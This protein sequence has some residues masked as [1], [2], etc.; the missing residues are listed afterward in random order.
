[1]EHAVIRG[2][3]F[4]LAGAALV[5]L[6]LPAL[7]L[8]LALSAHRNP[9]D[10]DQDPASMD[11]TPYEARKAEILEGVRTVRQRPWQETGLTAADGVPLRALWLPGGKKTAVLLHGYCSTPFN[12]YFLIAEAFARQGWSVLMPFMRGHGKSG[13]RTTLGPKEAQDALLWAAWAAGQ[14]GCGDVAVYGMSMSAAALHFAADGPWPDKVRVLIADAGYHDLTQQMKSLQQMQYVPKA[15]IIP[16]IR[17]FARWILRV[18]FGT[19]GRSHLERARVPMCFLRGMLDTSVSP[20]TVL[21]AYQA[22]G[23]RK[24]LLTAEEA[25]HTL[26][27]MA[28]G[29]PLQKALFTFINEQMIQEEPKQ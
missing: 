8:V 12:N 9:A 19:D 16:L 1:M 26:A 11:H 14:P 20:E 22:C 28:G 21:E 10:F 5:F 13:G 6:V 15:A 24:L 25:P 18:D 2:I 4:I 17:L 29:E 3:L 27:F 23:A 7:F